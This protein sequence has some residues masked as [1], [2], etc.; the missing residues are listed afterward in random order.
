MLSFVY[1]FCYSI[2]FP[3]TYLDSGVVSDVFYV[4]TSLLFTTNE[5]M[6]SE[7]VI[8]IDL[9]SR[10]AVDSIFLPLRTCLLTVENP[11][12]VFVCFGSFQWS[13]LLVVNKPLSEHKTI[14]EISQK[15]LNVHKVVGQRDIF[16]SHWPMQSRCASVK[17]RITWM[18]AVPLIETPSPIFAGS[19][20]CLVCSPTCHPCFDCVCV[21]FQAGSRR[22][23]LT[24]SGLS[25]VCPAAETGERGRE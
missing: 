5:G 9:Y 13:F 18:C 8:V 2:P 21:C 22:P 4:Q 25:S 23:R 6:F 1:L 15:L 20:T 14:H 17:S 19:A 12:C 7:A 24:A 10:I 16:N 3:A 11:N